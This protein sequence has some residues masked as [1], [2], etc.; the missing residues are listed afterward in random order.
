M[1]F[2][3]SALVVIECLFEKDFRVVV[4]MDRSQNYFFVKTKECLSPIVENI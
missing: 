4:K 1:G 2:V 3:L